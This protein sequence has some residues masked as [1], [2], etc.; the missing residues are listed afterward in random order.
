MRKHALTLISSCLC[1]VLFFQGV[2]WAQASVNDGFVPAK[3]IETRHFT[4][5]IASGVD[6][7]AL[8]QRLNINAGHKILAGQPLQGEMFAANSLADLLD[9]L[10]I[11]AC[12]VL[13]M[14]LYTYRGSIKIVKDLLQLNAVY[15]T[16]FGV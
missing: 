16:L 10:F 13:D 12:G 1:C 2:A 4:V 9:A 6:E 14:N 5:S 8:V 11:W 3:K 15:R 7:G